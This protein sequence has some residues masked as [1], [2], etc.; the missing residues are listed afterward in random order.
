MLMHGRLIDSQT[1]IRNAPSPEM[2]QEAM[3]FRSQ[4]LSI[5]SS[6]QIIIGNGRTGRYAELD[7]RNVETTNSDIEEPRVLID[8]EPVVRCIIQTTESASRA[9]DKRRTLPTK[10]MWVARLWSSRLK[11]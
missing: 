7:F 4:S 2:Y 11:K 5:D 6:A 8:L 10:E 9:R 1:F 3:R